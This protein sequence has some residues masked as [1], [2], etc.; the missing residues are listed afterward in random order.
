MFVYG[1]WEYHPIYGVYTRIVYKKK[2]DK[3]SFVMV[4]RE[5][6]SIEI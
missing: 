6:K 1:N 2:A 4:G 3:D 5:Y